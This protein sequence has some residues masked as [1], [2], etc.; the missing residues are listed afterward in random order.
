MLWA[1]TVLREFS[2]TKE[3]DSLIKS[4]F[5]YYLAYEHIKDNYAYL[6]IDKNPSIALNAFMIMALLNSDLPQ[7]E[8]LMGRLA[9][10]ILSS[11]LPDGS[12]R[13]NFMSKEIKGIDYYPGEA[14]LALMKLYAATNNPAYLDSVKRAFH[15]YSEYW[16]NHKNT[17]FIPWHTQ[18][19]YLLYKETRD[20][21]LVEFIFEMNDW[22]IDNYQLY[23]SQYMDKIGGFTKSNP[24]GGGTAVYLEGINDA[25]SL[26]VEI[27][28]G[29]HKNKYGRSVSLGTR[30]ILQ[31]QF[32]KANSFYLENPKRAIGGIGKTLT[33]NKQR[34]DCIQHLIMAL[35]KTYKNKIF[36]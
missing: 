25:Y 2:K 23:D 14:M 12:Y 1:L 4:T 35:F 21:E 24:G 15:Y 18:A 16:R 5:D 30:F 7:K 19:Y 11:Q 13:T 8:I 33:N 26:A 20:K 22:L 3:L 6:A 9:K 28:D 27:K 34:V 17:A 36:E 31:S 29:L 10:G 32:N